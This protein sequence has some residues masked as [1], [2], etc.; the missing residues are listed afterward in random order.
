[1]RVFHD[2]KDVGVFAMTVEQALPE[3]EFWRDVE[4]SNRCDDPKKARR[5]R[6]MGFSSVT[7]LG[8]AMTVRYPRNSVN[9]GFPG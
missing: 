3:D 4:A 5:C 2:H 6:S 9:P 7:I 8:I 1:M